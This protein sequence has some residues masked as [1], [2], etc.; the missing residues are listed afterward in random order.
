LIASLQGIVQFK[1]KDWIAIQ[2]NGVG[3]LTYSL[4]RLVNAASVGDDIHVFTALI[5]REDSLT[6]YGFP[7]LAER[8]VFEILITV[9]GVGPRL[10]LAILN[11]LQLDHLRNAIASERDDLLTRVP[12]IGSKTAKK[13]VLELKDKFRTLASAPLDFADGQSEVNADV[14]DALI[15]LGFSVVE[16]QTALQAL[17]PNTPQD[18]E[19]R[20]RLA[21]QRLG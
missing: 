3:Y 17:P 15:A 1:G 11:T 7:E 2:V 12:G 13:I 10:G 18:V 8:E 14:V 5:V 6:L 20:I 4:D 16:A 9:S 19:E 21:L